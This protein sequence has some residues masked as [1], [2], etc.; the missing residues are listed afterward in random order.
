[1]YPGDHILDNR[2]G[3]I[4]YNPSGESIAYYSRDGVAGRNLPTFD[5]TSNFD[6]N[7]LD[8]DLYPLNSIYGGVIVPRGTSI[9]GL[10]LRK[11]GN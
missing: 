6:L 11:T 1:M 9:V 8:N 4:P 10:D 2:P 7:S 3:W 5:P